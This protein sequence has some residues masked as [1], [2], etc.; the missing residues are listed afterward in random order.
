[1]YVPVSVRGYVPGGVPDTGGGGV[2]TAPP[3]PPHAAQKIAKTAAAA[4]TARLR[5][6]FR[7][8]TAAK[9][10]SVA[11]INSH[12]TH[13]TGSGLAVPGG[14]SRRWGLASERAVVVTVTVALAAFVPS[15]ATEVGEM[16]Q[17][18]AD[19]APVQLNDTCQLKPPTGV[20]LSV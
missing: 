17:V 19:G 14:T 7:R 2:V 6:T 4:S 5:R 11:S 15:G 8:R 13:G 16:E 18:A 12:A 10:E 3:P 1:V 9:E 20:T